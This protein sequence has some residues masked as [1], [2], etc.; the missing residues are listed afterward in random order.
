M[1][2]DQQQYIPEGSEEIL[3]TK[4]SNIPHYHG[5][6]V[7]RLFLAAGVITLISVALNNDFLLFSPAVTFVIA[8]L[9]IFAAA[10]TAPKQHWDEVF[11]VF[12]SLFGLAIF[13]FVAI[14][15][16]PHATFT[17]FLVRQ[18]LAIIF[19]FALYFSA[20]TL[21]GAIIK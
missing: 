19:A 14:V 12:V 2:Q 21:R 11:N 3:H 20:K 10:L 17:W 1:D 8:L 18:G 6:I 16:Y 13:E 9:F 15:D 7:R 5:D 4:K